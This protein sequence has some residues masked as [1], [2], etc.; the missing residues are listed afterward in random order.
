MTDYKDK[1]S[2]FSH[3]VVLLIVLVIGGSVFAGWRVFSSNSAKKS[4]NQDNRVP[5]ELKNGDSSEAAQAMKQAVKIPSGNGQSKE[6]Q[7]NPS[8]FYE[9][10][11]SDKQRFFGKIT[12]INDEY[13]KL[14]DVYY[15][16]NSSVLTQLGKEL[17]GPEPV[18]YVQAVKVS[19]LKELDPSLS[20]YKAITDFSAK[21]PGA[22]VNDASPSSV[23]SEYIKGTQHQAVFFED[24][25]TYYA[26]IKNFSGT[27]LASASQ[28]Y[29]L[30]TNSSPGS[31]TTDASLIKATPEEVAKYTESQLLYWENLRADGQIS[32]AIS[33]HQQQ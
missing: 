16:K 19:G 13:F 11:T 32:T 17:R 14:S 10:T 20:E 33:Q 23:I 1:E 7:V 18:M 21:N 29:V 2:G 24:G 15:L 3:I 25:K 22:K 5:A 4:A 31:S 28:V 30:R 27:F 8:A 12:K 9:V 26:K 6:V